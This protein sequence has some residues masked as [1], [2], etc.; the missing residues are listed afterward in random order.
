MVES[1]AETI[2]LQVANTGSD[3]WPVFEDLGTWHGAVRLGIRWF[4]VKSGTDAVAEHRFDLPGAVSPGQRVLVYVPLE[5]STPDGDALGPG[6][7]DVL[8]GLLQEG[9]AWFH[10]QGGQVVRLRVTVK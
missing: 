10:H 4:T 9:M 6:Q 1:S 8:M 3:T 7:Y 5:A 2:A